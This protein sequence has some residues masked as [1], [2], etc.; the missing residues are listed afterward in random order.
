M[1]KKKQKVKRNKSEI[2][3]SEVANHYGRKKR[4]RKEKRKERIRNRRREWSYGEENIK[5]KN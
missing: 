1:E 4:K 2:E 5:L 3:R